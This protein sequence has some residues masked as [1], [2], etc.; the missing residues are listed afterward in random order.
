M[1]LSCSDLGIALAIGLIVAGP[2]QAGDNE[3][4]AP[5]AS[6]GKSDAGEKAKAEAEAKAKAEEKAKAEAKAK[7]EEKAKAENSQ[8]AGKSAGKD[9]SEGKGKSGA[10]SENSTKGADNSGETLVLGATLCALSDIGSG[11]SGCSGFYKGNLNGGSDAQNLATAA[12]LN[13]L[14]STDTFTGDNFKVLADLSSGDFNGASVNFGSLLYGLTVVS[15]HVG[16]ANGEPGGVGYNGTAFYKFDAGKQGL[17]EFNF[18]RPG[19][20]NARLFQTGSAP[21]PC[22]SECGGGFGIT[23]VPEPTTWAMMIVGFGGIGAVLRRRRT[24]IAA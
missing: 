21:P 8:G 10:E 5:Q 12:A 2:V 20:S 4:K 3:V 11:A 24:A 6:S 18:T 13:A 7:A 15:F 22:L 1:R 19:L 17:A 23:A 14:L 16:G 9:E